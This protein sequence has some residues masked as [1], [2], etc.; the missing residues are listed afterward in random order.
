VTVA[1]LV[2]LLGGYGLVRL[3]RAALGEPIPSPLPRSVR[4]REVAV[5]GGAAL[6]AAA[7]AA[8]LTTSPAVALL[9]AAAAIVL[10][11]L[12]T[13]W[14][15]E[16]RREA[17][18][19]A[20]VTWVEM[21]RDVLAAAAGIETA[22]RATAGGG[23]GPQPPEA[24]ADEVRTLVARLDS[25][26]MRLD[27]ALCAFAD[28]IDDADADEV[29]GELILA[30]RH[31]AGKLVEQLTRIAEGMREWLNARERI[32]T[33]LDRI[34]TQVVLLFGFLGLGLL[35]EAVFQRSYLSSFSTSQ[36]QV[37]LGV[38]CGLFIGGGAWLVRMARRFRPPRLL[39]PRAL[40]ELV[41]RPP[42]AVVTGA[43]R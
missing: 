21:L 36:G 1:A 19:P 27:D 30:S 4:L 8:G 2:G 37:V 15:R 29:I 11:R 25:A 35:F 40:L 7:V 20:L 38:A 12:Y 13:G 33:G 39:T 32:T 16:R 17:Q 10:P 26:Q 22:I 14:R 6:A 3:L 5:R 18:L 42:V 43:T 23:D 41:D 24:I 34:R 28:D 9:V 31:H